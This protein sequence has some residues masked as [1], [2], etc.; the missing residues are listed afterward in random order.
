[1]KATQLKLVPPGDVE[2]AGGSLSEIERRLPEPERG[3][4][5]SA[6]QFARVRLEGRALAS[7]EPA[8]DHALATAGILYELR[9]DAEALAAAQLAPVALLAPDELK[10]VRERFGVAVGGLVEGVVRMAQL[11][12]VSTRNKV[13]PKPGQWEAQSEALRKM[14]L[15]MVQDVRVVLVKLA[16]HLQELRFLV[17]HEPGPIREEKARLT[18][19]LFAPLASRLGVWQLKWEMEDLSLRIREPDAY[20]T[21]ARWLDEKRA[22]RESYIENVVAQLKGELARAGI[23]AEVSG[24]PKN[25]YSIYKKVQR[26]SMGFESLY[27]VRAVRVLVD[28]VKDC[29]AALGLTHNLWSP[30]PK[31]FDDYIAKPKSNRYR[32]LH[33][34]VI[35]PGGRAVEIQIRTHEMHQHAELGVAAHWRYKEGVRGGDHSFDEKLAWLRQILDWKESVR[36]AGELA[37]HFRAGLVD[38][39]IYVLTP[40]G[41]VIELPRDATP[42]DF[43]YHVHSGL[44]HRC[45]GAKVD[46]VMVPLNTPL[47][48]GQQVE[49]L[50][51]KQGGPSR[52]WL[53]PALGYVKSAGARSK[54]RQ[55]F[56]R[57]NL[58]ASV[59]QGRAIVDKELHR[60]GAVGLGIE[61]LAAQLGYARVDDFLADAGRGDIRP[62]Q[63]QE[64]V[65][66]LMTVPG[67]AQDATDAEPL[68]AP[69]RRAAPADRGGV[70]VVG[71]DRL[72]TVP[73]RCCKPVPPEPIVGFVTR[74]RGVSVHRAGCANV[75][76]LD[77]V[78]VVP[79]QW[80]NASGLSFAVDI[81]VEAVSRPTLAREISDVLARDHIRVLATR[82]DVHGTQARLR[83]TLEVGDLGQLRGVLAHLRDVPGVAR[84]GR[85]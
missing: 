71:V 70:L 2:I 16:D 11:E 50:P 19:E 40:Q 82:P 6:V 54:I 21:I 5:R 14:L 59:S 23:A 68:T 29:Y 72:L 83:I 15:A 3:L 47:A 41:R 10:G 36:D 13:E 69:R 37:E 20:R 43:A 31:E 30:I 1:M 64:A 46:G 33:T 80:G 56:H 61:K 24:R 4:L 76:R 73:A 12:S 67:G 7:G 39:A 63:L 9:L 65:R 49:I 17:K 52:D 85:R 32:S 27:D 66:S 62:R 58:A 42:V 53:N 84:V 34:A 51:L 75:G 77:P 81:E 38:D 57:Q 44:G 35:G 25:I 28:D 79:A 18:H 8:L 22:D 26:K 55:W 74:G 45:R 60:Q 48:N 78:R